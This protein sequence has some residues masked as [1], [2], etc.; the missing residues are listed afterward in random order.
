M[1][2]DLI[3]DNLYQLIDQFSEG[4]INYRGF[5]INYMMEMGKLVRY[6]LLAISVRCYNFSKTS[7]IANKAI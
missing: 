5:Y 7:T 1:D 4:K 3:E 2:K 6:Y